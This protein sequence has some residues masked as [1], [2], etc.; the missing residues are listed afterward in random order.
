MKVLTFDGD[1]MVERGKVK[2]LHETRC[3]LIKE[4]RR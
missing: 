2:R 4:L 1:M 3:S